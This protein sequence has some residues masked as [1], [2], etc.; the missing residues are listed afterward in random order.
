[1]DIKIPFVVIPVS[2][3]IKKVSFEYLPGFYPV[4]AEPVL[5]NN[6]YEQGDSVL[7]KFKRM[8]EVEEERKGE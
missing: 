4:D 3:F 7:V 8:G 2:D 6:F 5:I 1:M